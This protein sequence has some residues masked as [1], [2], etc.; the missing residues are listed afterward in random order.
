LTAVI[1]WP[2]P[3]PPGPPPP[4]EA[5]LGGAV[6]DVEVEVEAS[7]PAELQADAAMTPTASR[8]AVTEILVRIVQ[9]FDR[10]QPCADSTRY[11]TIRRNIRYHGPGDAASVHRTSAADGERSAHRPPSASEAQAI[12]AAPLPKPDAL[13]RPRSRPEWMYDFSL[14]GRARASSSAGPGLRNGERLRHGAAP[15]VVLEPSAHTTIPVR[16]TR[17]S[18]HSAAAGPWA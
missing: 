4:G 8:L 11:I 16:P 12:P 10:H 9:S 18:S 2:P 6:A 1:C 17:C 13:P 7:E 3:A 5:P 15:T 14:T